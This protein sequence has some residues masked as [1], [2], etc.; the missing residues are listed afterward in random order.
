V[1]LSQF[2][3]RKINFYFFLYSRYFVTKKSEDVFET[4]ALV[5]DGHMVEV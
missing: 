3:G 1:R 2:R 4:N 5:Q